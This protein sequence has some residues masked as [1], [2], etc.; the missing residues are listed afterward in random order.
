MAIVKFYTGMF[1]SLRNH[2]NDKWEALIILIGI[3]G[4][5]LLSVLFFINSLLCF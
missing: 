1:C 3:L 5:N 4:F 2:Y